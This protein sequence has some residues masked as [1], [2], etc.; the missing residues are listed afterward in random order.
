MENVFE[1][2]NLRIP[3]VR[4]QQGSALL[5][6]MFKGSS[7]E[8]DAI[9]SPEHLKNP[10]MTPMIKFFE[11]WYAPNN[12]G[13][14]LYGNFDPAAVKPLIE[15]TFGKMQAKKL[16]ERKPTVPTPLTKNEKIKIKLGYS[17]SIV[18]G[19][20]GVKKGHPDEFKI[21]FMLSILNNDYNIGLF[22]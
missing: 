12:M 4:S 3:D 1:E 15:K 13:L 10:S 17:P 18:W 22:D 2:F 21:D 14:L 11:D 6:N 7:Y 20:E 9:G 19:Y 5:S 16:P 8:R